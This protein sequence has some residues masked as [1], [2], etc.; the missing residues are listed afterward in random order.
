MKKQIDFFICIL[1]VGR[2]LSAVNTSQHNVQIF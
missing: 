2:V 1:T